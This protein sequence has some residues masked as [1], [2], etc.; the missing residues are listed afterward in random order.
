MMCLSFPFFCT[1]FPLQSMNFLPRTSDQSY[2]LPNHMWVLGQGDVCAIFICMLLRD[3]AFTQSSC[4]SAPK[5]LG[6]DKW[7]STVLVSSQTWWLS[8]PRP[9]SPSQG[10]WATGWT[11]L[12]VDSGTLRW[13]HRPSLLP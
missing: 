8:R 1:S 9:A 4:S 3:T 12:P 2:S 5:A 13:Q 11:P 6:F 10:F 7:I